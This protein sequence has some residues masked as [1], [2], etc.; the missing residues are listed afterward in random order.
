MRTGA[1]TVSPGRCGR[2]VI[3]ALTRERYGDVDLEAELSGRPR[4]KPTLAELA[5]AEQ[6]LR[7][8]AGRLVRDRK[9][10]RAIRR[11]A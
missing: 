8:R 10:V 9:L 3:D 1:L 2:C 7:L 6:H 5:A 11:A 4:R